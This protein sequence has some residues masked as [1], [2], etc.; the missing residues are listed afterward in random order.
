MVFVDP[1]LTAACLRAR[2][3]VP[4]GD[5]AALS[6]LS[7]D[8]SANQ[9]AISKAGGIPPIISWCGSMSENA[10]T[11]A[12]HALL[13]ISANNLTTQ[14]SVVKCGGIAPLIALAA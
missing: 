13:A 3:H 7:F 6:N 12:A 2:M 8:N 14:Q 10:Q 9:I 5:V 1:P 4:R 11:Q